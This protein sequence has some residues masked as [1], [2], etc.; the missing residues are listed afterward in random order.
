MKVRSNS[1]SRNNPKLTI[2]S[3][4]D[5]SGDRDIKEAMLL[6]SEASASVACF[7][8]FGEAKGTFVAFCD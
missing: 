8:S 3:W 4:V 5:H 6:S 7:D 1:W 2:N